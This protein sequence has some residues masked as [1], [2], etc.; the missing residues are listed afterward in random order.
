MIDAA[1][2][3]VIF[4][5]DG[6]LVD[7]GEFHKQA[8]YDLARQQGWAYNDEQFYATFGMQNY[9]IIPS[10]SRTKLSRPEIDELS[11]WKEHRFRDLVA[12]KIT[13]LPGVKALI[14]D[15]KRY[16][17]VLA[18]GSSGPHFNIEMILTE[19]RIMSAFSAI[20]AAGDVTN[21][22]P[23]PDT[24]LK[25]A[26]RLALSPEACVVVEDAVQGVDA[27]RAAG[28]AVIA[29]TNTRSRTDLAHADHVIDSL[30]ELSAPDF[31]QLLTVRKSA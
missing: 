31:W 8:W 10:L 22:K 16:G 24:F 17:F 26:E 7:T 6:V 2:K 23:A 1:G 28:M 21:G 12:G 13:L 15:L 9:Q 25:A 27:A 20:V 11:L 30:T 3:G 29:V 19:T 18:L 14:D 5:M 4:D